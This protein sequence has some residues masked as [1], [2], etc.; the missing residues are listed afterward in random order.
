MAKAK[1]RFLKQQRPATLKFAHI[2]SQNAA[3]SSTP[4]A[5]VERL[6]SLQLQQARNASC[7]CCLSSMPRPANLLLVFIARRPCFLRP[8]VAALPASTTSLGQVRELRLLIILAKNLFFMQLERVR[9]AF[10]NGS[11]RPRHA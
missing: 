1:P 11:W 4:T 2:L 6:S 8:P 3:R 10:F 5:T 9:M 7:S